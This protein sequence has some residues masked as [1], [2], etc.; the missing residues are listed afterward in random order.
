MPSPGVESNPSRQ[1]P[2]ILRRLPRTDKDITVSLCR[3]GR[4]GRVDLGCL[5]LIQSYPITVPTVKG[6]RVKRAY[7]RMIVDMLGLS[8]WYEEQ[9]S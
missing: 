3:L 6:R 1:W 8:E 7:V 2:G 5:V 4:F 9:D